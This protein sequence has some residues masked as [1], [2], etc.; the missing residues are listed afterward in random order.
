MRLRVLMPERVLVDEEVSKVT[1]EAPGGSFCLLERHVDFVSALAPGLLSF[2][3]GG[4]EEFIAVDEGILVKRGP[5]VKVSVR[6]AERGPE[7]GELRAAIADRFR[8]RGELE[9]KTRTAVARL[10]SDFIRSILELE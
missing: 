10:Q 6:D 9:R 5:S 4:G 7:L 2:E 1:A 3:R 8:Q